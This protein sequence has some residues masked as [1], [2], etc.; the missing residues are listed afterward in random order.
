MAR[1][2]GK[3]DAG[4]DCYRFGSVAYL[5]GHVTL[6]QVQQAL[7]EQV[8]DDVSGRKH[9]LLGVILRGKGW[10]TEDQE[11]AILAEMKEIGK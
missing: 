2:A 8:E 10:I 11:N 3:S 1:R 7:A 4:Y 6:E 9:R 5:L